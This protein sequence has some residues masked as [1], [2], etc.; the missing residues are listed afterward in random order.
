M[1][2]S[3][4]C[5]PIVSFASLHRW[6]CKSKPGN[7]T[8]VKFRQLEDVAEQSNQSTTIAHCY[9]LCTFAVADRAGRFSDWL[10]SNLLHS[11]KLGVPTHGRHE[12][13][14]VSLVIPHICAAA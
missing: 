7:A 6:L 14:V 3:Q 12:K 11:R 10:S 8:T 13:R 4:R 1:G 5:F 2:K 9:L